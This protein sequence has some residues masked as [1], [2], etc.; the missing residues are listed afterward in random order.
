ML[1]KGWLAQDLAE[2]AGL[3]ASTVSRFLAGQNNSARTA[4]KVATALGRSVRRYIAPNAQE[5]A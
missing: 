1:A 2:R 5:V 3:T 4:K